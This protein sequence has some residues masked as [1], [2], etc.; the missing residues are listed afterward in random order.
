MVSVA[1]AATLTVPAAYPTIPAAVAAAVAGDVIMVSPGTYTDAINFGGKDITI[2]STDPTN[3]D[4][5]AA[6]IIKVAGATA[7]TFQGTETNGA[8]LQGFTV[9]GIGLHPVSAPTKTAKQAIGAAVVIGDASPIIHNNVFTLYYGPVIGVLGGSPV[10]DGN[11][12]SYN[13]GYLGACIYVGSGNVTRSAKPVSGPTIS[14][15]TFVGNVADSGACVYVDAAAAT[16]THNRFGVAPSGNS[17]PPAIA[18]AL[19]RVQGAGQV[20]SA[21]KTAPKSKAA[22]RVA[23]KPRRAHRAKAAPRSLAEIKQSL[24]DYGGNTAGYG[25]AIY[26]IEANLNLS[27]NAFVNNNADD[28]GC[29]YADS[30]CNV[31]SANDT[32]TNDWTTDQND[33]GGVIWAENGIVTFT[34]GKF[35]NCLGYYGGVAYAD[36]D[37]GLTFNGCQFLYCVADYE[38]GVAYVNS[39]GSLTFTGCTQAYGSGEYAGVFYAEGSNA[40]TAI[41]LKDSSF[42][43]NSCPYEE[44]AVG[45]LY[46]GSL[47]ATNCQFT[48]NQSYEGAL[49]IDDALANIT[50]C[51]FADN[52]GAP[53]GSGS[54]IYY[55]DNVGVGTSTI[56]ENQFLR[57]TTYYGVIELGDGDIDITGNSFQRN[58]CMYQG[59]A[60]LWNGSATARIIDNTFLGNSAASGGAIYCN[61]G[62]GDRS[63]AARSKADGPQSQI[64]GN[65]FRGNMAQN[66]SDTAYGGA[67]YL[68]TDLLV[69]NNVFLNNSSSNEGGAVYSSAPNAQLYNNSFC[70]NFAPQ[71]GQVYLD[72]G[73]TSAFKNNIV[74]FGRQG[75]GIFALTVGSA[76]TYNDVYQNEGGDW[77]PAVTPGSAKFITGNISVNPLFADRVKGDLHLKSIAGRWD[78]ATSAWVKDNYTSRCIDAGDPEFAYN[79]ER[80][81]NGNRINMGAYGN[82]AQASKSSMFAMVSITPGAGGDSRT[83]H[84]VLVFMWPVVQESVL[85]HMTLQT[86]DKSPRVPSPSDRNMEWTNNVKLVL[87]PDY[88][89]LDASTD[90]HLLFGANIKRI[91]GNFIP[92]AQTFDFHTGHEPV[93]TSCSPEPADQYV[94]AS[95]TIQVA[96]DHVMNKRAVQQWFR[97]V[98][99]VAGTFAWAADGKSF[100]YT[101]TDPLPVDG[102]FDVTIGRGCRSL[103]GDSL[104]RPFNFSFKTHV[105]EVSPPATLAAAAASTSAGAQITVRLNSAAAVGAVIRNVAGVEVAIVAP[106]Q[107]T[108]GVNT[109]L[110]NGKSKSGTSVPS[111][112]YLIQV[113]AVGANGYQSSCLVPLQK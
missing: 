66:G 32:F 35:R 51:T 29:I 73:G 93:V 52:T 28:G 109:L 100:T 41:T 25:G 77:L 44:Y 111:G 74:A 61:A 55:D 14:N 102:V 20:T 80:A 24:P 69:S 38:G 12:F 76:Y 82:T 65:F 64:S 23:D 90:Y 67:L 7:V 86:Q 56:A 43:S 87:K 4:V 92:Y 45:Y 49:Y 94:P 96:F 6:T 31:A 46:E 99:E 106:T 59:G 39:G 27:D 62:G 9:K 5:V 26:G 42:T 113:T 33:G 101:P 112:R 91:D 22:A 15:N 103:E 108:A 75:G 79:L 63:V 2:K 84:A 48:N 78:P 10:I 50:K 19:A 88:P 30:D 85:N 37:C 104:V 8:K 18:A 57:N 11:V 95:A 107:M 70:G 89:A 58:T 110:W 71:G 54:V 13:E 81:P 60:I 17:V 83:G 98:P 72:E 53:D 1:G 34:D 40:G 68:S 16:I 21:S 105:P 3:P 97:I 47:T 36:N